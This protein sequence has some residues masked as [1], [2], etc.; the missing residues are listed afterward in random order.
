MNTSN[1]KQKRLFAIAIALFI[2]SAVSA[3]TKQKTDAELKTEATPLKN[4][5]S[6]ITQL[7]PL[8]F[9]YNKDETNKLNLPE[10]QQ[11]GFLAEDVQKVLPGLVKSQNKMVPAGKNAFKT[12]S[13]KNVDLESLIPI[14]VGSIQE[15]QEEIQK[16][17]SEIQALKSV[18]AR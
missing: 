7:Q 13:I 18:A 10:G 5:L 2:S 9:K 8:T 4:S 17:R 6:Y 14:L 15:Q 16:L 1:H 11:Y 3:Q 12:T